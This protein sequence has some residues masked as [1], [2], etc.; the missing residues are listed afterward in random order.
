MHRDIIPAGFLRIFRRKQPLIEGASML[1]EFKIENFRSYREPKTFSFVASAI[2]E[3]P[4][5]LFQPPDLDVR[6]LKTA[7]IYGPNG[8]GKSNLLQA[9]R[10]LSDLLESP[11]NRRGNPGLSP[12][13]LDQS[14]RAEPTR[15]QVRFV[16]DGVLYEYGLAARADRVEE[17]HLTAYPKGR[18]QDWFTREGSQV[19]FNSPHLR[20]QKKSL[21]IITPDGTPFLA[22]AAVFEHPQ[23]LIPAR[24]MITNLGGRFDLSRPRRPP[25]QRY[26]W[27]EDETARFSHGNAEFRAWADAFLRHADVGIK[28]YE[29]RVVEQKV[30]RPVRSPDAADVNSPPVLQE[31]TE[32]S[33][34]PCF[35]HEGEAGVTAEFHLWNESHGTRRLF[36]MLAPVYLALRGGCV[37][38]VD[39]LSASIHPSLVKEMIRIFHDTELNP[40][41]AQL[42]FA[43]HDTSLLNQRLFRRDQVWFT[44]KS[45]IG[46]TDLYSLHDIKDVRKEE[47]FE[48]GYL[49]GRYGALPFFS[50][51][52]FPP[53]ES[54]TGAAIPDEV[55]DD[56]EP[57]S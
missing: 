35:V 8:S 24:W 19:E 6:L 3:F 46:A 28:R 47:A 16:A 21:A 13:L 33:Y 2:T 1:L 39:E 31:V 49:R 20:G 17:E 32:E 10:C 12:F 45:P 18:S 43:T 29:V 14:S 42:L 7:A 55:E 50:P 54:E 56:E 52:D 26:T 23:L 53:I 9:M 25:S 37:A 15:F 41:N 36:S 38:V 30:R 40:K 4:E 57:Y 11:L 5:N 51:F 48:D 34:L 44:E 22:V 27:L